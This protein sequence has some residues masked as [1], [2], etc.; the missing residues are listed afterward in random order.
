MDT[1]ILGKDDRKLFEK[2]MTKTI[3]ETK[4]KLKEDFGVLDLTAIRLGQVVEDFEMQSIEEIT[5]IPVE[6]FQELFADFT[7]IYDKKREKILMEFNEREDKLKEIFCNRNFEYLK[8]IRIKCNDYRQ[9]IFSVNKINFFKAVSK[10][11]KI[12]SKSQGDKKICLIDAFPYL[13]QYSNLNSIVYDLLMLIGN[14][15]CKEFQV[16]QSY[17]NIF[18]FE[19]LLNIDY[20]LEKHEIIFQKCLYNVLSRPLNYQEILKS[21]KIVNKERFIKDTGKY[22]KSMINSFNELYSESLEKVSKGI[23]DQETAQLAK[24]ILFSKPSLKVMKILHSRS[25]K[26]LKVQIENYF[27]EWEQGNNFYH[28]GEA[29][30]DT[31]FY[32]LAV[33]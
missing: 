4:A 21:Y 7:V 26:S 11:F 24:A 30:S 15:T 10:F 13:I 3:S 17:K 31:I 8:F 29:D 25:K 2:D 16:V 27:G 23:L 9:R 20:S 28:C 14:L 12:V 32:G 33:L 1:L 5:F 19:S 6:Q 22:V 18:S